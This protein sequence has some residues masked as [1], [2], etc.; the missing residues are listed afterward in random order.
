[1]TD[2]RLESVAG[3]AIELENTLIS[4]YSLKAG[5]ALP[6]ESL[7]LNFQKPLPR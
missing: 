2:D 6:T 1:L 4:S 3:G 7:S 5:G